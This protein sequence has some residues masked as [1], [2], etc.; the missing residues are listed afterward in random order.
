MKRWLY[1]YTCD[2]CDEEI[3]GNSTLDIT[4]DSQD[5]ETIIVDVDMLGGFELRCPNCGHRYYVPD[6]RDYVE[7]VTHDYD[8]EE[9]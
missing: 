3:L 8:E 4:D 5:E 7:D 9:V 2:N 1:R 6:L